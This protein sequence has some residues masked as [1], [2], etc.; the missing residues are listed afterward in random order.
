MVGRP[1][2]VVVKSFSFIGRSNSLILYLKCCCTAPTQKQFKKKKNVW[3][4]DKKI[5][6]LLHKKAGE[7]SWWCEV[8]EALNKNQSS[9]RL[10]GRFL[11]FFS[12]EISKNE[13][14]KKKQ[15]RKK[16]VRVHTY[17]TEFVT[18]LWASNHCARCTHTRYFIELLYS[19]FLPLIYRFH[20]HTNKR[21]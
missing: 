8:T 2:R 1:A 5:F 11:F 6:S 14:K 17:V 18:P 15:E 20:T 9:I 21:I 19:F 3:Q 16:S 7:L 13:R 12:P 4:K 10:Y